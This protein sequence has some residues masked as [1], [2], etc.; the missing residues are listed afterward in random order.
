MTVFTNFDIY[1]CN[2]Q[3]LISRNMALGFSDGGLQEPNHR[4]THTR[5]VYV[6]GKRHRLMLK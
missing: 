4:H 2:Y 3:P 5:H 6:S 1:G